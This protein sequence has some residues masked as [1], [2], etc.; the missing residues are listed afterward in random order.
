M[1]KFP[2]SDLNRFVGRMVGIIRINVFEV[3]FII[4]K[5]FFFLSFKT[6]HASRKGIDVSDSAFFFKKQ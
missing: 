6:A 1:P 2:C 5:G 3:F 4:K